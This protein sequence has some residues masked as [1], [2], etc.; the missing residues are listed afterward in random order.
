M[1][2]ALGGAS[3]LWGV[4]EEKPRQAKFDWFTSL[5][6]LREIG[7]RRQL[8]N[9]RQLPELIPDFL[10]E[11]RHEF[12]EKLAYGLWEQRGRPFGSPEIDW[13]AAERVVYSSLVAAGLV[14]ASKDDLQQ[15]AEKIYR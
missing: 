14:S 2:L 10:G 7:Q 3:L 11:D 12:V 9:K 1:A 13:F 5:T 8:M 4:I 15:M 6:V